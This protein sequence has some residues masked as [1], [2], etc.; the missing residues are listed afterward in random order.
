MADQRQQIL[1][2]YTDGSCLGN[3]GCGGWA[4]ILVYN[5][6]EKVL[7]GA[8]SMTTN[9][10]MELQAVIEGLAAV[11]R[12]VPIRV[13]SDSAY[14]ISAF[15]Q[16]W[17]DAWKRKQWK[18]S[19]NKPVANQDL[20]QRLDTLVSSLD[21]SFHK[22]KGHSGHAYNERCDQLAVEESKRRQANL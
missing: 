14:V 11:K 2:I 12:P 16:H 7:S 6:H 4:A 13:F 22:V 9:N 20:W 5:G 15:N 10:R 21:V 8:E 3:P 17:I 19:L 18:N 1:D